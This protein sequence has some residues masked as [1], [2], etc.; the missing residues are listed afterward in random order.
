MSDRLLTTRQ[1]ARYLQ[2]SEASVRRWAD[3]GLLPA[4]RIGVRQARRFKES[5]LAN[6]LGA[7]DQAPTTPG[8]ASPSIMFHGRPVVV[9]SHLA[10]FYSTDVGRLRQGLPLLFDGL[11]QLEGTL[12]FAPSA[13]QKQYERALRDRQLDVDTASKRGSFVTV[14]PSRGSPE[15]WIARFD[16]LIAELVRQHPAPI[17]FVAEVTA[18]LTSTGSVKALLRL[19]NLLTGVVKRFP[20]VVLCL[21]DV[22][23]FNGALILE[24]IKLHHETFT[25]GFGYFLD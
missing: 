5:D 9:S 2:A 19:E 15:T 8:F 1:A 18:G 24:A 22:R 16:T 3:A 25:Y 4:G 7:R 14:T 23:A 21:Y 6:F 20:V 13:I 11:A 17:R 10:G 12:L